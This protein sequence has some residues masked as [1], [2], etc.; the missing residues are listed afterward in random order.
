MCA[1]MERAAMAGEHRAVLRSQP[2]VPPLLVHP[3]GNKK[4]EEMH[5]Q[6][7]AQM[8]RLLNKSLEL[9]G[10]VE[11]RRLSTG[12]SSRPSTPVTPR[13]PRACS[14]STSRF[15]SG[16]C[17]RRGAEALFED[18]SRQPATKR[19]PA[20]AES[21]LSSASTSTTASH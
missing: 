8:G 13:W 6:L 2:R 14:R 18:A 15:R 16:C 17:A 3:S 12:R 11:S 21:R 9:R 1:E 7:I 4:L 5:V 19:S 20:M 10:G